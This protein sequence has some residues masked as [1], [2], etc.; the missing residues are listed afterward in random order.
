MNSQI[1]I[2]GAK[3]RASKAVGLVSVMLLAACGGGGGSGTQNNPGPEPSGT[4]DGS[5]TKGIVQGGVVTLE[6][7]RGDE[8]VLIGTGV[9]TADGSYSFTYDDYQG[10]LVLVC[11]T[12]ADT[13]T[14]IVCDASDGP[15]CGPVPDGGSGDANENGQYDLGEVIPAPA[16]FEMC[17]CLDAPPANGIAAPITPFT[18]AVVERAEQREA[19]EDAEAG[20]AVALQ[21]A[22]SEINQLLGGIDVLRQSPINLADEAARNNAD[23][24]ALVYSALLA[25]VTGNAVAGGGSLDVN[26]VVQQVVAQ[27]GNGSVSIDDLDDLVQGAQRQ[28]LSLGQQDDS[29]VLAVLE[30]IVENTDGPTFDPEPSDAATQTRVQRARNLIRSVRTSINSLADYEQPLDAFGVDLD[31]ASQVLDDNSVIGESF[32]NFLDAAVEFFATDPSCEDEVCSFEQDGVTANSTSSGGVT[33]ITITGTDSSDVVFDVRAS[34]PAGSGDGQTTLNLDISNSSVSNDAARLRIAT[35]TLTVMLNEAFDLAAA[36]DDNASNNQSADIIDSVVFEFTGVA[37]VLESGVAVAS[38]QG[39]FEVSGVQATECEME[40]QGT[41]SVSGAQ[42]NVTSFTVGGELTS[43]SQSASVNLGF[44]LANG[45]SFCPFN[46]T[47]PDNVPSATVTLATD[48]LVDGIE[49]AR[50]VFTAALTDLFDRDDSFSTPVATSSLTLMRDNAVEFALTVASSE[51]AADADGTLD[52]DVTLTDINNAAISFNT[53]LDA[54]RD[55]DREIGEITVDGQRV[56][57]VRELSTG[58]LI[59]RFDDGSFESLN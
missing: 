12:S 24:Q 23:P 56:G 18:Q 9:T 54:P 30:D 11:V 52:I 13:G 38:A 26:A 43:D 4:I 55:D 5:A 17:T 15:N 48:V 36:E 34:A 16:D 33:S 6:E 19:A 45:R 58:L 50:V 27:T 53:T 22:A 47:T 21:N 3:A 32:F 7:L 44:A 20:L 8:E 49:P 40:P 37:E 10:G 14:S 42:F 25:S 2:S 35:G 39:V 29:G 1:N 41:S 57:V 28:L 46:P 59:A 51:P 31:S